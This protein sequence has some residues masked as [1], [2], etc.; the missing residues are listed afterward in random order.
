M[1]R[2]EA[3][4]DIAEAILRLDERGDVE[5]VASVVYRALDRANVEM[6]Y[7]RR[8][9]PTGSGWRQGVVAAIYRSDFP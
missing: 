7:K 8:E 5:A 2:D 4:S 3:V 9:M 1:T 6:A